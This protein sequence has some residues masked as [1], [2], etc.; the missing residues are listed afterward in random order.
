MDSGPLE[1]VGGSPRPR[2]PAAPRPPGGQGPDFS[3]HPVVFSRSS[4]HR[5]CFASAGGLG[6][7]C[8]SPGTPAPAAPGPAW[9][10]RRH[11][12]MLRLP[13]GDP[14]PAHAG[15]I[16]TQPCPLSVT[17]GDSCC[18]GRSHALRLDT[19]VPA[20]SLSLLL[21]SPRLQLAT[22]RAGPA[23]SR[24]PRTSLPSNPSSH[25]ASSR[26]PPLTTYRETGPPHLCALAE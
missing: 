19:E 9:S 4:P 3:P 8:L 24:L 22:G 26:K 1:G 18:Y 16:Q 15:F 6:L 21:S 7:S 25:A 17:S 2:D 23:R 13:C 20:G 12:E 14:D 10:C 11:S 5:R